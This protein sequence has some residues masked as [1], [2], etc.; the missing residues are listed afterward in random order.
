MQQTDQRMPVLHADSVV[1]SDP[2]VMGGATFFEETNVPVK[3]LFDY[4][5]SGYNL[6]TFLKFHPS[7]SRDQALVAIEDRV[8]KDAGAVIHSDPGFVSGTPTFVGTRVPIKNLF[9]YLARGHDLDEFLCGFPSVSREQAVSALQ[10]AKEA[11]ES[12]AY[13]TA[14]R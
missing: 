6:Q 12:I 7:V 3:T 1:H 2:E 10:I 11:L 9:D 14:S 13:E 8:R 5:L 4:L